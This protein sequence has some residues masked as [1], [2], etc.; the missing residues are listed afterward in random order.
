MSSLLGNIDAIREELF[1]ER[2]TKELETM[3]PSDHVENT[4]DDAEHHNNRIKM[5]ETIINTHK[6]KLKTVESSYKDKKSLKDDINDIN[7]L[8]FQKSW[9]KLPDYHKIEKIKEFISGLIKDPKQQKQIISELSNLTISKKLTAKI[10]NYDSSACV[11]KSISI[12][13]HNAETNTYEIKN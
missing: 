7:K 13:I 1:I 6:D 12:L 3:K 8:V 2:F 4:D 11:I 5:L 9:N 10:V